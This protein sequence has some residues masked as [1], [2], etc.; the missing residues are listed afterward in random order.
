MHPWSHALRTAGVIWP[1]PRVGAAFGLLAMEASLVLMLP[2]KV[3]VD[4]MK[5]EEEEEDDEDDK[6]RERRE[7]AGDGVR[8]WSP[9]TGMTVPKGICGWFGVDVCV[10]VFTE[11][12]REMVTSEEREDKTDEGRLASATYSYAWSKAV[13]SCKRCASSSSSRS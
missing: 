12:S 1:S 3:T 11:S 7:G 5:T 9:G 10:S 8:G 2:E 4:G 6:L 13:S